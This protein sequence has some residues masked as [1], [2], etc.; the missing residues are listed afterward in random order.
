MTMAG[1]QPL[2]S[3]NPSLYEGPSASPDANVGGVYEKRAAST[4]W[5]VAMIVKTRWHTLQGPKA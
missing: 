4:G 3:P 1:M 5:Q 2:S